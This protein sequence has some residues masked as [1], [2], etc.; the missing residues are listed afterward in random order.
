MK[1]FSIV[2]LSTFSILLAQ[3]HVVPE[4]FSGFT[5]SFNHDQNVDFFGEGK[6]A[7]DSYGNGV[8]FGY[9]YNGTFGID[10][11]YGYSLYDRKD[12]YDFN[13]QEGESTSEDQNFNFVENFR[14]ENSNLGDKTFSFGLTYYLNESQNLFESSLPINLSL[15]LRY[16]TKNYSS[17][18][19]NFLNQDFYGKFYA[20]ELGAYKEIETNASF[21]IIPR[22]KLNI[23]NEKNIYDSSVSSDSPDND[24]IPSVGGSITD[25]FNLTSTYF[26]IA[27][28]FILRETS[29][30]QP[31]IE[32]SIANKYGTTH[33]GLRFGF[34]F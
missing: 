10:L 21:Y 16:G 9:V 18:A 23:S 31:F 32:T 12:I 24:S 26:E 8:G 30:G 22:I 17:D 5:A 25:S 3:T 27:L 28:P 6:F 33:L 7:R 2:L 11:A 19:L 1:R 13:V 15:G 29:T 34:L 4:G 14:S 20:F